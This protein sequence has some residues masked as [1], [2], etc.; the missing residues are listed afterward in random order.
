MVT[1][2]A[3]R[4]DELRYPASITKIMTALLAIGKFAVLNA[5]DFFGKQ[6]G[7]EQVAGSSTIICRLRSDHCRGLSVRTDDPVRQ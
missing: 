2:A 5:A 1:F 7:S 6:C 4:A 3:T